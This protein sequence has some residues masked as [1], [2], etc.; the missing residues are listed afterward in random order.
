MV[1]QLL[2]LSPFERDCRPDRILAYRSL[3]GGSPAG[4]QIPVAHLLHPASAGK[5]GNCDDNDR[6]RPKKILVLTGR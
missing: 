4:E 1:S 5:G 3:A 2:G 6:S